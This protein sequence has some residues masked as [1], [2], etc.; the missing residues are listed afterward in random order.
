MHLIPASATIESTLRSVERDQW[1]TLRGAL[2]EVTGQDGWSW[3]S[4]LSRTDTGGGSCE[5]VLV[6]AVEVK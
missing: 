4:S 2:V 1:V 6:E 3:R 5:L